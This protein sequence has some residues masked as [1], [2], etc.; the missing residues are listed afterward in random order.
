MNRNEARE[1]KSALMDALYGKLPIQH[2]P[3][4]LEAAVTF[5]TGEPFINVKVRGPGGNIATYLEV[6]V[7]ERW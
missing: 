2:G 6:A 5:R 7:K 3:Y 4:K 1:L